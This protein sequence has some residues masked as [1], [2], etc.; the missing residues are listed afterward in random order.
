MPSPSMSLV[1]VHALSTNW[2]ISPNVQLPIP[3]SVE[4]GYTARL[5][6]TLKFRVK[7]PRQCHIGQ[8]FSLTDTVTVGGY[9]HGI[10][11]ALPKFHCG[12]SV[13]L[14]YPLQMSNLRY[15]RC[16]NPGEQT[17]IT[18]MVENISTKSLG[19]QSPSRRQISFFLSEDLDHN[20]ENPQSDKSQ[21]DN[22]T[23][24]QLYSLEGQENTSL[25]DIVRISEAASTYTTKELTLSLC[26]TPPNGGTPVAI[27]K[28]IIPI[29]ISSPFRYNPKAEV[30]L[31]TNF[32]TTAKEV[33]E[34]RQ[35]CN[36]LGILMDIWNISHNGHFELLGPPISGKTKLF[37]LYKG[38][39]IVVL[40]NEF[41]YF[42]GHRMGTDL[43]DH[44]DFANAAHE[45][46]NIF[47]AGT[48]LKDPGLQSLM[49]FLR[50][51][52][53]PNSKTFSKAKHL[54]Q[55]VSTDYAK[56]DFRDTKFIWTTFRN[57]SERCSKKARRIATELRRR[58]PNIRFMVSWAASDD[59]SQG[60]SGEIT[61]LPCV[62]YDRSKF[63]VT[64]SVLN[65]STESKM[66]GILLSLPFSR[67]LEMLWDR[68][69]DANQ[70]NSQ[71]THP[72][73]QSI[74][75]D[76]II[77]LTRLV[78]PNPPWPDRFSQEDLFNQLPRLSAFFA[79]NPGQKFCDETVVRVTEFLADLCFWV[80]CCPS[81][82]PTALSF[83]SRRKRLRSELDKR[84]SRFILD[85]Y[86]SKSVKQ[87]FDD[88][89]RELNRET[90]KL[91]LTA[92]QRKEEALQ[93]LFDNFGISNAITIGSGRVVDFEVAGNMFRTQ[94]EI[95]KWEEL[96]NSDHLAR[97][98]EHAKT[99]LRELGRLS[100]DDWF[101]Q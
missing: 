93:F 68:W 29:Q 43:I 16:L 95:L 56:P 53:Y 35:C 34:W 30:L 47:V 72:I 97:D 64:N 58:L 81:C 11:R 21:R 100:E 28:Y 90:R 52:S 36:N 32:C 75:Y 4:P 14:Q 61:V 92:T 3:N 96:D 77:Q 65:K 99:E 85:H 89:V 22:T 50:S 86:G 31:V 83:G 66:F 27:Q 55:A 46:T 79:F 38:K 73:S 70:F 25:Q 7:T 84:I 67:R 24:I 101:E 45:G 63:I 41:P 9:I 57:N 33:D 49:R 80:N 40:G 91:H 12:Q 6:K 69:S 20:Q 54:L 87:Q 88:L 26:L 15:L 44:N 76:I 19:I 59:T 17:P 62:N 37:E 51:T 23:E 18:W 5:D 78:D 74:C 10:E 1:T 71:I 48:D 13:V 42:A 82:L 94:P 8:P 60:P 98:L 39:A 2:L